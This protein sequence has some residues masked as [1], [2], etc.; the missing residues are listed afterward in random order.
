MLMHGFFETL[1]ARDPEIAA[2][3]AQEPAGSG[4]RSSSSPRRTS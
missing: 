1:H 2:A 3:I 4:T